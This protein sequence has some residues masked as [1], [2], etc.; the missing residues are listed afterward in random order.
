MFKDVEDACCAL[1]QRIVPAV[2]IDDYLLREHARGTH[3]LPMVSGSVQLHRMPA[4]AQKRRV[5]KVLSAPDICGSAACS[6]RC[7]TFRHRYDLPAEHTLPPAPFSGWHCTRLMS[8]RMVQGR[9]LAGNQHACH[10]TRSGRII[11]GM[12]LL[13]GMVLDL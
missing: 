8:A 7:M 13:I 5:S 6:N 11:C 1:V 9:V 3:T 4:L 2:L 10:V 12:L